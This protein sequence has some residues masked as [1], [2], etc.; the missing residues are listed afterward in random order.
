VKKENNLREL[1]QLSY[2]TCTKES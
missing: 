1:H 2:K